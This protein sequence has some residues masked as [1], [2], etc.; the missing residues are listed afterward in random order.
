MFANLVES[1]A[2]T[3]DLKCRSFF[4][5]GTLAIYVVLV[6]CAGIISVYAYKANLENQDLEL[7][8][9][10]PLAPLPTP[11]PRSTSNAP[12][13]NEPRHVDVLHNP[14]VEDLSKPTQ[15]PDK[16]STAKTNQRITP[17]VPFVIDRNAAESLSG[18]SA[19]ALDNNVGG[20]ND[21]PTVQLDETSEPPRREPPKIENP[22]P[23]QQ[24]L[25]IGSLIS[26]KAI[27]KYQPPYPPLA[28]QTHVSGAV[29]VNIL[30][31][32]TG[33]VIAAHAAAGHPLLTLAAQQ[34]A[35]QWRFSPTVLNGAP[36]KVSGVITFNFVLQ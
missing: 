1:A 14:P 21:K 17:D 33:R 6:A 11:A 20:G 32:E 24:T 30:V 29:T 22:K 23:P 13:S 25:Q 16:I 36:V 28:R 7:V 12:R 3:G 27:Y 35:Y 31:D 19:F 2:H 15:L 8:Q 34:A 9:M 5:F 4:F 10:L 18:G 26:G